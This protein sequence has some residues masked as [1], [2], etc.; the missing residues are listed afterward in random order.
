[1]NTRAPLA[2]IVAMARGR[3]IGKDGTLPWRLPEDLQHFKAQTIGHAII[4]GRLTWA[5]IGRAL[6]GRTSV[7]V[8]RTSPALPEGVLCAESVETAIAL[9]RAVD[10]EPFVI[11]GGALYEAA[12]PAATRLLVTELDK[13]VEGGDTFFPPLPEGFQEVER[14]PGT[15]P[16]V[17][18]VEYVRRP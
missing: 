9:A 17:S 1:M 16:H 4:M 12:L 7:V 3:V 10:D 14:R 5:S 18:F 2:M 13:D 6:P 15:T 8:S 11:G